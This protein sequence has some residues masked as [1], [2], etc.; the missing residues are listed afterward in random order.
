MPRR[1]S[2]EQRGLP[3]A[4][5]SDPM[6]QRHPLQLKLRNRGVSN[7]LHLMFRHRSIRFV[8]DSF[9]LTIAFQLPNDSP[10]IDDRARGKIDILRRHL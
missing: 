4:H 6:M 3:R 7:A 10:E 5:K 8:V 2:Q 9:N 1:D